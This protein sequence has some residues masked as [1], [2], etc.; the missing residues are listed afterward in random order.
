MRASRE[1]QRPECASPPP[2]GQPPATGNVT[3]LV[4]V[5]APVITSLGGGLFLATFKVT[6]T[7]SQVIGGSI[8]LSFP[9]LPAGVTIPATQSIEGLNPGETEPITLEFQDNLGG[10]L[11]ALLAQ[12]QLVVVSS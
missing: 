6:D 8:K 7:S 9:N 2:F 3:S 10:D 12:Q 1:R 11:G 4:S 5:S